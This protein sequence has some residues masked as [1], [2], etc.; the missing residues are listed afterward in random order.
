MRFNIFLG[1][2]LFG[3]FVMNIEAINKVPQTFGDWF[4]LLVTIFVLICSAY[5]FSKKE[6]L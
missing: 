3:C 1:V 4:K 5:W 2:I 6:E